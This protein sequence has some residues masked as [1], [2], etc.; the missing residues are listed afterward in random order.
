MIW[1]LLIG[2]ILISVIGN[3]VQDLGGF[4]EVLLSGITGKT[5]AT[6]G[7]VSFAVL[8]IYKITGISI[9][10][11]IPQYGI[12]IIIIIV[13]VRIISNFWKTN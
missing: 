11:N 8:I 13:A 1:V 12:V 6:I 9:L 7:I 2:I 5:I 10:R 3:L 4:A